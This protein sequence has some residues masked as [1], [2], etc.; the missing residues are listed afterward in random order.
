[1]A[2]KGRCYQCKW[3]RDFGGGDTGECLYAPPV[4][5]HWSDNPGDRGA[6]F[7]YPHV[8]GGDGCAFWEDGSVPSAEEAREINRE[9][10]G[11]TSFIRRLF[12]G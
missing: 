5:V 3:Y 12:G 9:E 6:R 8:G 11:G 10:G 4:F 1:M 7:E 2:N